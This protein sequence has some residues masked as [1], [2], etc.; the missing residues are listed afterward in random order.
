MPPGLP[1]GAAAAFIPSAPAAAGPPAGPGA[2]TLLSAGLLASAAGLSGPSTSSALILGSAI[3]MALESRLPT[4]P[5][6]PR[7]P[8]AAAGMPAGM[9]GMLAPAG[10]FGDAAEDDA[11]GAPPPVPPLVPP[12]NCNSTISRTGASNGVS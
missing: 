12:R 10:P 1:A 6:P 4:P 2:A 11:A 3:P 7:P 9:A 8:P 5:A